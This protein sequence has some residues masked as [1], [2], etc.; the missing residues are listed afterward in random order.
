MVSVGGV[1][2]SEEEYK[3]KYSSLN[4]IA[5]LATKYGFKVIEGETAFSIDF[6][7]QIMNKMDNI[8]D[9]KASDSICTSQNTLKSD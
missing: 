3:Q 2:M 7:C 6:I 4:R 1:V 9:K 5:E 8:I